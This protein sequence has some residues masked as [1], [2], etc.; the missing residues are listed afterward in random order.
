MFIY[1]GWA[2]IRD[3][4]YDCDEARLRHIAA[5]LQ[6][7]APEFNDGSGWTDVR[8]INGTC[9]LTFAGNPNHR[10][11]CVF[12]WFNWLAKNAIGSFGLMYL[13]D[14]E[15]AEFRNAFRVFC[16]RRGQVEERIDPFLSPCIP[17]IEDPEPGNKG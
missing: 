15:D 7:L 2:V 1:H 10:H 5:R 9:F 14:D 8:W 17:V 11:D 6:E 13:W 4:T 3:G 16:L 12:E